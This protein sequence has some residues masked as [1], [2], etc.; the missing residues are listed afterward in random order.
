MKSL[1]SLCANWV[2]TS[3]SPESPPVPS[4]QH[5][6]LHILHGRLEANGTAFSLYRHVLVGDLRCKINGR[7]RKIQ[8]DCQISSLY[9]F[10]FAIL[11]KQWFCS[12]GKSEG[13]NMDFFFYNLSGNCSQTCSVLRR[14]TL[15][16]R[17]TSLI[18]SPLSLNNQTEL[19]PIKTQKRFQWSLN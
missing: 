1:L 15:L 3:V 12:K 4:Q 17:F 7:E 10:I 11:P 14:F 8:T 13:P 2:C 18:S 6:L 5:I 9:H 16:G 19:M